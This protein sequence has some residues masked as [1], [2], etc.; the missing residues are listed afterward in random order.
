MI[1]GGAVRAAQDFPAGFRTLTSSR[2]GTTNPQRH[3][4]NFDALKK[5][6]NRAMA[7]MRGKTAE[8][9]WRRMDDGKKSNAGAENPR[10]RCV[11]R[12]APQQNRLVVKGS[13]SRA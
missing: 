8:E 2:V 6:K 10:F 12:F 9:L 4:G 3:Q 5:L 13:V 1:A 7:A 11:P